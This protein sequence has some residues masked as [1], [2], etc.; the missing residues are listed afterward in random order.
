M[1]ENFYEHSSNLNIILMENYQ[2]DFKYWLT[3][4]NY[5]VKK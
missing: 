3:S 1:I 2:Y 5:F 4:C